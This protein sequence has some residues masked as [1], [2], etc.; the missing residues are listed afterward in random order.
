MVGYVIQIL[1]RYAGE[2]PVLFFFI[3]IA[4]ILGV[5]ELARVIVFDLPNR[6]IRSRNIRAQGWPPPH[7]DADGDAVEIEAA[8]D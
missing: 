1:G 6:V 2:H 5:Y 3:V 7:C 8:N 4:I